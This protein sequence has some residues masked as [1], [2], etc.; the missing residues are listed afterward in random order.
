MKG[1]FGQKTIS[2]EERKLTLDIKRLARSPTRM[3]GLLL[4]ADDREAGNQ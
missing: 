3:K 1:T 4:L 2:T